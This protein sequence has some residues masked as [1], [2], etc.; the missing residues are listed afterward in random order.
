MII[1]VDVFTMAR[2][3]FGR[4][5]ASQFHSGKM[6]ISFPPENGQFEQKRYRVA[7]VL[8]LMNRL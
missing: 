4:E 1:K 8:L 2:L 5:P 7:A 3:R 6:V